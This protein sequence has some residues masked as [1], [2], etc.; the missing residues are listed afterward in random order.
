MGT[1]TDYKKELINLTKELPE[2]KLNE[3]LD[4]GKFRGQFTYLSIMSCPS[5]K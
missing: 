2:S 5:A 4:F 3:L 1:A